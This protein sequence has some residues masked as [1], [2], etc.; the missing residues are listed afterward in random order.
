M[1]KTT[2]RKTYEYLSKIIREGA[3][4]NVV[5]SDLKNT[6]DRALITKIVYGTVEKYYELSSIVKALCTKAPKPA[7]KIILLQA[8]YGI[9][10]LEIP[11]YAVVNAS[12][13]LVED[14]GKREL[15]GFVNAV[16]KKAANGDYKI[17]S[18]EVSLLEAKY[19]LP[20]ALIKAVKNDC[21]ENAESVLDPPRDTLE[22]VRVSLLQDEKKV[23]NKIKE[24]KKSAVGGYFVKNDDVVKA[25]FEKGKLTFQSPSSMFAVLALGDVKGKSVLELCSAPGGKA[26]FTAE[27]GG[28][29]T[30]CD[31]HPVRVRLI[32]KYA[33]RMGVKL[34]AMQNDAKRERKEWLSKFDVVTVDAPCSGLGVIAKRPD[35]A[36]S[37]DEKEYQ[38]LVTEQRA[39]LRQGAKYVKHGGVLLYSTC[40]VLKA[41][42]ENTV[43]DFLMKNSDFTVEPFEG[44]ESGEVTLYPN[45]N[46]D[47]FYVA[48][49]R[50]K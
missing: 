40:T 14:I 24:Y 9:M 39:I 6:E 5:L 34:K 49:L 42:N 46:F 21:G 45:E 7:V 4:I 19:N 23:I 11:N 29:V 31:I 2:L 27:R 22:H 1:D 13:D 48:K 38:R 28:V 43:R 26:V 32:E 20:Y 10:Y 37:Y 15:K 25:L 36:L 47:G 35:I 17:E 18:D 50:R 33:T 44:A 16:L 12:V 30:A 41:E 3:Y 8:I